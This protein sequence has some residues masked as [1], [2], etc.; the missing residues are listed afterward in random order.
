[1]DSEREGSTFPRAELAPCFVVRQVKHPHSQLTPFQAVHHLLLASK[2]FL[3][4]F[5]RNLMTP[6]ITKVQTASPPSSQELAQYFSRRE[7]QQF[8]HFPALP[9]SLKKNQILLHCPKSQEQRRSQGRSSL[10]PLTAAGTGQALLTF[11]VRHFPRDF[12]TCCMGRA[13]DF[14][15][16]S[17]T[18]SVQDPFHCHLCQGSLLQ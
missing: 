7:S 9:I 10:Q 14:L 15:S 6:G 5:H 1:M 11:R 8:A 17:S 4:A 16:C 12:H 18:C 13:R 3:Y 2:T